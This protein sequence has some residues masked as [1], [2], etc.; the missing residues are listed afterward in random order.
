MRPA[1][2][3]V[4]WQAPQSMKPLD[5]VKITADHL[6]AGTV[7]PQLAAKI[8][9]NAFRQYLAGE[10]DMNRCFGLRPRRGGA[11]E[12]PLAREKTA[13]RDAAILGLC[14]LVK[15]RNHTKAKY[16]SSLLAQG[17]PTGRITDA[18]L[19]INFLRQYESL[20]TKETLSTR[21]IERILKRHSSENR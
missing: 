5:A 13:K 14:G 11:H 19:Q 4:W 10:T 3:P 7:V 12:T 6:E 1:V 9:S 15:G 21:T 18:D 17:Q 8:V 20:G 16:V 2:N